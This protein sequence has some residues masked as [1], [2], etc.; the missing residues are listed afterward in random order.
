M[1]RRP[2]I[3]SINAEESFDKIQYLFMIKNT[4]QS[5]YKGDI[6][7]IINAFYDKHTANTKLNTETLKVFPQKSRRRK[8]CLL[9]LLVFNTVLEVLATTIRQEREI[10]VIQIG[11]EM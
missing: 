10:K 2:I 1:D 6:S 3:T 9:S 7:Q 5:G 4:Q 11:R 8:G